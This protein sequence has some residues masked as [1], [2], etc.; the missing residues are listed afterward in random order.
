MKYE[1]LGRLKD[2]F[3]NSSLDYQNQKVDEDSIKKET[4]EETIYLIEGKDFWDKMRVLFEI[5][6]NEIMI[7]FEP[8]QDGYGWP[9]KVRIVTV[10]K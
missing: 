10:K 6:E 8:T 2:R 7:K 3:Q 9:D 5:P 1:I 4:R